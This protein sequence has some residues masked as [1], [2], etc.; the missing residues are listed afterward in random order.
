MKKRTGQISGNSQEKQK[1]ETEKGGRMANMELL[2]ILSM[3]L[4]IVLHFLGK[5]GGLVKLTQESMPAFGYTAWVLES[6]CI[7]AVNV[8]MLISGY[9][10]VEGTFRV[11][12]LLNLL[13]QVLFYSIGVGIVAACFGLV[14]EEGI[15]VYYLLQLVL[16]ISRNHYWFVT[17]YFFMYLFAP[18]LAAGV[19][20]L[21]KRQFQFVLALLL[22]WFSI[23]KSVVPVR[24]E[25]DGQGYDCLWYLCVFLV[26]AYIRLYGVPFLQK[27]VRCLMGYLLCC[28]GIFGVTFALRAVY[29]RT[30]KLSAI[31]NIC[32]EYN[33]IL[34][35]AAAVALFCLF[36][37]M[38]LREGLFSRL[39]CRIAPF[40]LGVYLLHEHIIVR[41]EWQ[42]WLYRLTGTPD[43]PCSLVLVTLFA[44]VLVF[45]AGVFLDMARDGIFR[46]CRKGLLK[47]G[48]F[49]K[50]D[51]WLDT[52]TVSTKRD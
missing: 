8:Y 35:L 37:Q 15:S 44:V 11:K 29:L 9:F 45:S 18:L 7:V 4:V 47:V 33:H 52:L 32:C 25:T 14:P 36:L 42:K 21:T 41:Y 43:N 13:M 16:P 12:R 39:V 34:V 28:A 31:L 38:R 24:L 27:K 30:G 6:L 17:A 23:V 5:G 20:R 1:A 50:L 2:R 19:K 40:T 46:L 22:F 48:M 26:A 3:M 51:S 49:K 10:L